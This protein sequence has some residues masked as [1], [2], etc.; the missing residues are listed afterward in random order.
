M[1][2]IVG[3]DRVETPWTIL[4]QVE[5]KLNSQIIITLGEGVG[6]CVQ[7]RVGGTGGRDDCDTGW[8]GVQEII[9][10]PRSHIDSRLYLSFLSFC[11]VDQAVCS[12]SGV[13]LAVWY[14][15][16]LCGDCICVWHMRMGMTSLQSTRMGVVLLTLAGNLALASGFSFRSNPG[17]PTYPLTHRSVYV[18]VQTPLPLTAPLSRGHPRWANADASLL[19]TRPINRALTHHCQPTWI[20]PSL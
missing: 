6:L 14:T 13:L 8:C 16:D 9:R 11:W 19:L 2:I 17:T 4:I 5:V 12:A 1:M 3:C 10:Q 15:V 18:T 20:P 7:R